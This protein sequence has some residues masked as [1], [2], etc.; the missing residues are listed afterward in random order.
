MA[1]AGKAS[2]N[3]FLAFGPYTLEQPVGEYLALFRLK[4]KDNSGKKPVVWL[5]VSRIGAFNSTLVGRTV[6]ASDFKQSGV[7]QE[8]AL[9]Y[10]RPE[11]GALEFRV[12]YLGGTDLSFDKVTI[13]KLSEFATDKE[14]DGIWPVSYTHLNPRFCS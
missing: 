11:D 2:L 13:V 8:I 14:Q 6:L 4:V 9:R 1:K 5:D 7:Y 12:S 3:S 10:V